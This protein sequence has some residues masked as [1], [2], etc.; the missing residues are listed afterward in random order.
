MEFGTVLRT[1]PDK[2]ILHVIENISS[3][4]FSIHLLQNFLTVVDWTPGI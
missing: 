1:D 4:I 3:F 2:S